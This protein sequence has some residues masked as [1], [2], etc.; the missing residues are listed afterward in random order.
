MKPLFKKMMYVLTASI[1]MMTACK[2][3]PVITDDDPV[4]LPYETGVF[5][6]NEGPF[7][8][9]SGTVTFFNRTTKEV[10]QDIFNAENNRPL[11]NIV[12]SVTIYDGKAYIVVNNASKVEVVTLKDFKSTGAI[13][14]I[15]MPRFLAGITAQKAYVSDWSGNV[16][17]VNLNS[18]T[19]SASINVGG[20]PDKMIITGGKAYVLGSAGFTSDSTLHI[21][22]TATDSKL[23]T[24][25]IGDNPSDMTMDIN[26]KIW[27]ICGG[28]SDWSNPANNTNA[29]LVR[30]NPSTDAVEQSFDLGST[31][32]G[33]KITCNSDKTKIYYTLSGGVYEMAVNAAQVPASPVINKSYYALGFD[34]VS[35]LLYGADPKDYTGDGWIY[36]YNPS[37]F[38]VAD[39][40]RAGII[41]TGFA[42]N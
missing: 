6:V 22:N 41:P 32:F 18:L 9:G 10:R 16:N 19:V 36:R 1:L 30:L 27:I 13:N 7:Q 33:A 20:A 42:F 17:V 14:N 40:F 34:N 38:A 4:T 24:P 2:K 26:G 3:E 21:I 8:S 15:T 28:I 39:S 11:G 12:Q 23:N 31:H 25:V 29:T 5:V 35:G 37:G